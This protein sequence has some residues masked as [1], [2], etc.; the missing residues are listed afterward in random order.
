[1]AFKSIQRVNAIDIE[2]NAITSIPATD[3]VEIPVFPVGPG[4]LAIPASVRFLRPNVSMRRLTGIRTKGVQYPLISLRDE[5]G[6]RASCC[7]RNEADARDPLFASLCHSS[8][9]RLLAAVKTE[10]RP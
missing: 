9:E 5:N 1:M 10:T 3:V 7:I 2:T 8:R 6:M 4:N